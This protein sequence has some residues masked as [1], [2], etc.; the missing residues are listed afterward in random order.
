MGLGGLLLGERRLG[1]EPAHARVLGVL[2]ERLDL[3]DEHRRAPARDADPALQ[4]ADPPLQGGL[5][6]RHILRRG[7]F[8]GTGLRSSRS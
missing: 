3:L 4:L 8:G 7:E 1:D 2:G 6:H 5:A